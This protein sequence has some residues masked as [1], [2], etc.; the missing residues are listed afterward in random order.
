MAR[1]PHDAR[2]AED[3]AA[4]LRPA[5]DA[6]LHQA[7]LRRGLAGHALAARRRRGGRARV[8]AVAAVAAVEAAGG[9]A[10]EGSELGAHLG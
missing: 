1:L 8:E 9:G 7:V 6:P 10:V 3:H 2:R 5:R 4:L